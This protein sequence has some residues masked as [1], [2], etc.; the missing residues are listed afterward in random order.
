MYDEIVYTKCEGEVFL[1]IVFIPF[2]T[3][4]VILL[5]VLVDDYQMLVSDAFATYLIKFIQYMFVWNMHLTTIFVICLTIAV[6]GGT[7]VQTPYQVSIFL[8]SRISIR[9]LFQFLSF[10]HCFQND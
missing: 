9:P 1:P 3:V 10:S 5:Q 7:A 4:S 2:H 6:C 8:N